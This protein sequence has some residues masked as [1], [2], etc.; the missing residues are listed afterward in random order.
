MVTLE[1]ATE[2]RGAVPPGRTVT[3]RKMR[4]GRSA[5]GRLCPLHSGYGY[6]LWRGLPGAEWFLLAEKSSGGGSRQKQPL[7]MQQCLNFLFEPQGQGSLR[8]SFSISSL[9]PRTI[10]TPRLTCVSDGNPL[11]R[12][13][14]RSKKGGVLWFDV[15]CHTASLVELSAR[16]GCGTARRQADADAMRMRLRSK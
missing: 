5:C 8:P 3:G 11:R 14:V 1:E 4:Q 2:S 15:V 13:L 12:L 16:C 7:S 9:K 6:I 10:R